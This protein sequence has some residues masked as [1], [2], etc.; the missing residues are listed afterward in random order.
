MKGE[1][2]GQVARQILVLLLSTAIVSSFL[3]SYDEDES[4]A[5]V[6]GDEGQGSPSDWDGPYSRQARL[7]MA[8]AYS[9]IGLR[10]SLAGSHD[11]CQVDP[12]R[13]TIRPPPKYARLCQPTTT[14][15]YGCRGGC[16]SYTRVDDRNGSNILRFC[17]CCRDVGFGFQP[18]KMTCTG[19]F[20]LLVHVKFARGCECRPCFASPSTVNMQ[21]IRDLLRETSISIG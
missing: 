16:P 11:T 5:D 19:G 9:R 2:T 4:E 21:K 7:M 3:F 10:S 12:V 8:A 6:G 18:V 20:V 15:S 14:I 1:V 17:S 13:M